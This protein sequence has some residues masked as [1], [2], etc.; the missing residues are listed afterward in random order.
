MRFNI[1]PLTRITIGLLLLT[2][3]LLLIGEML[4]LVP[5]KK[6]T[7]LASKK[8]LA[9]SLAVQISSSIADKNPQELDQLFNV[10]VS[11]NNFLRSIGLQE[12]QKGLLVFTQNHE[13]FWELQEDAHSTINQIN[14][15]IYLK[16]K[17]WGT[18]QVDFTPKNESLSEF[19]KE[20]SLLSML[21]FVFVFGFV[22]YWLFLKRVLSELDPNSVVP[23]RVRSAFDVLTEGLIMLDPSERIVL[24]NSAFEKKSGLSSKELIGKNIAFLPWEMQSNESNL[25]TQK[26][27]WSV[28]FET[29][30][31]PPLSPI[32]LKTAHHE[33]LTLEMNI[34]PITAPN[35]VIKG[36]IVTI[37][38]VT[39]LEKKNGELARILQRLEKSQEEINRQNLELIELATRDPLTGLLNRR[40]L[41]EGIDNL[42]VEAQNQAGIVSCMMLDIDHFKSVNDT[43]GHAAGDVVIKA[44]ADIIQK[45]IRDNDL[46]GRYGGEEFVVALPGLNEEEAAKIAQ[47]IRLAIMAKSFKE[48]DSDLKVTSSFGVASTLNNLW[49]SDKI[50]D[51]ADQALYVAK[52]SGRNRVVCY[53][54]IE[55]DHTPEQEVLTPENKPI[56]E[57]HEEVV[58]YKK[59][60]RDN[61]NIGCGTAHTIILDRLSQAIKAAN[62]K[63]TNVVI[64]TILIDTIALVN[65]T[66]GHHFAEKLRTLATKRLT[67]IF[68]SSDSVIPEINFNQNV[69]LSRAQDG[70]FVAILTDIEQTKVTTW[71]LMRMFKELSI[72]V[73]VEGKEIVMTASIG[74]SV[75]PTDGENHDILLTHSK[76][77][78]QQAIHEG[79]GAFCFYDPEMN[80]LS[81]QQLYIESQLHLALER[82]EL[83]LEYQPI[84]SMKTGQVEKL[85][86]LVRWRHPELGQVSPIDFIEIAEH[87][88]LI[89]EIGAWVIQNATRQLKVWQNSGYPYLSMSINLSSMQFNHID[90]ANEIIRIIQK[91]GARAESIIFELTETAFIKNLD[92]MVN[93]VSTL[94]TAGFQIAIDDF[95][96]G[97]SSLNYLRK[98]PISLL[99]L[100]KSIIENFPNDINDVSIVSGLIS[101]SH[102]LGIRVIAEGV[103]H[104]SQLLAL[105]DLKCDEVQGYLVSRP[106]QAKVVDEFLHSSQSRQLLR[107]IQKEDKVLQE[108][109]TSLSE[110]LNPIESH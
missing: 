38:D 57:E 100:D 95:G 60:S 8:I 15:P 11:R 5:D 22:L 82:N 52:T 109:T 91:E 64:L 40:S 74:G 29:K 45:N 36:A 12:Y 62:R 84:M 50:V 103:E 51:L 107:N 86:A 85:E 94:R 32:K 49:D 81:K 37:D 72:P 26:F 34:A 31:V 66:F 6:Q 90:L 54:N 23:D 106:L 24:V 79:R 7:E 110:I 18:L 77:A 1:S 108:S 93:I 41:F 67:E 19:F 99:K 35:E 43:F 9:E 92:A 30:E 16:D 53:S 102:N 2:L 69:S 105:N 10:L 76:M 13:K 4:G 17:R 97:Y 21:L 96:T 98:L 3:S 78:L 44:F 89:K 63:Q 68:R 27:P 80:K 33:T 56:E 59:I 58:S 42:L 88:G 46:V 61:S 47:T 83:Y 101:L 73:E 55:E 87:V 28:L 71:V 65:N 39:E 104:E 25:R 14:V 20:P 70:N 48:I 75:Y